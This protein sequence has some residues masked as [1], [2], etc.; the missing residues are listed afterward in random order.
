MITLSLPN[1]FHSAKRLAYNFFYSR[2]HTS[3]L[4]TKLPGQQLLE[5]DL[6]IELS[7]NDSCKYEYSKLYYR[8]PEDKHFSEQNVICFRISYRGQRERIR[9]CL[10][11][12]IR[13][14]NKVIFRVDALPYARGRLNL[15]TLNLCDAAQDNDE[16]AAMTLRANLSAQKEWVRRQVEISETQLRV[17]TPHYP[18]SISLELT[19][20]CNLAC[21]H[22]SSHGTAKLHRTHN[23]M[24]AMSREMLAALAN[25]TF[26]HLTVI[27]IVGRG[28]STMV[29]KALWSDFIGHIK[30][31]QVFIN[32]VTNAYDLKQKITPDLIA[33]IDTLTIS[34]DGIT[35][36]TFAANR[37]GA[38]LAH[39]MDEITFFHELRKKAGLARRP[40]LCLSW[41]LKKNNIAEFP[42]FIRKMATFEPDLIYARHLLIFHEK[43]RTESLLDIPDVAN[44]Y[45]AE[46]YAL[47]QKFKIRSECPPLFDLTDSATAAKP[48]LSAAHSNPAVPPATDHIDATSPDRVSDRC[49]WIHRTGSILSGGEISTCGRHYAESAGNLA[50]TTHFME[51]WN[52]PRMMGIR[53][54][55]GTA[56]EWPQ[57]RNCWYRESRYD[58]Q[59]IARAKGENYLLDS[60]SRFSSAAWDFRG[61]EAIGTLDKPT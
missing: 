4:L 13:Q 19:P 34:I 43:D 35:E 7:W 53:A 42:D 56:D 11:E 18:E 6:V 55:F 51:I 40:K 20:N 12:Q 16:E 37:G 9:V 60:G 46:A 45:L 22:C 28:E 41:T 3:A 38:S 5:L 54:A 52:G 36:H 2:S 27:N 23:K 15:H 26:P 48:D 58:A 25:E 61:F 30:K 50:T 21:G 49:I 24:N 8:R 44:V 29:S 47:M 1:F 39:I 57:C 59:R 31:H 33:H 10:P 14:W 17:Y 32:L